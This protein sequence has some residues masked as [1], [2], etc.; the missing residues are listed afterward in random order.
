MAT[1]INIQAAQEIPPPQVVSLDGAEFHRRIGS[2]SR[3]SAV[4]FAG[5]ILTAAA[6]YFFKIYLARRLGA[7]ALGLYAL[8]MSIVGFLGLFD[9]VGLP[10]AAA[11]FVAEYSTRGELARL[12]GFLRGGLALL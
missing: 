6:G 12:G 3:Q 11:R 10:S 9:S 1:A 8:G 7:E 5:T 4:Y 2:I